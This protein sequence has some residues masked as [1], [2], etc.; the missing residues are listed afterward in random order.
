MIEFSM[1]NHSAD[2]NQTQLARIRKLIRFTVRIQKNV[3]SKCKSQKNFL[4]QN[5]SVCMSKLTT[6]EQIPILKA[7]TVRESLKKFDADPKILTRIQNYFIQD[8][9]IRSPALVQS[10]KR[11]LKNQGDGYYFLV[12]CGTSLKARESG[13]IGTVPME[14]YGTVISFSVLN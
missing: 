14:R 4:N 11:Y 2:P 9:R 10:M 6:P 1:T 12:R 5:R 7:S 13:L 8:A 3:Q